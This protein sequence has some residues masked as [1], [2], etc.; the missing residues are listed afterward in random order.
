MQKSAS[1]RTSEARQP[2]PVT[3]TPEQAK[4]RQLKTLLEISQA[5]AEAHD[6][7]TAYGA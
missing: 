2:T 6:L 3:T 4:T 1:L 7:K 5:L